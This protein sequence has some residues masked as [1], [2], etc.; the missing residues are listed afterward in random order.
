MTP[1]FTSQVKGYDLLGRIGEGAYGA[2][3]RARQEAVNRDVVI[4]IIFIRLANRPIIN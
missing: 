1:Q 3:Y 4:K 2:V